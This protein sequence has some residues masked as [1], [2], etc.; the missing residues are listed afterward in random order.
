MVNTWAGDVVWDGTTWFIAEDSDTARALLVEILRDDSEIKVVGEA[1][2]GAEA[3]EM[4]CQLDPDL[5]T[6]DIQMPKVD[7]FTAIQEI[8]TTKPVP[9]VVISALTSLSEGEAVARA[10]RLNASQN[11]NLVR[12]AFRHCQQLDLIDRHDTLLRGRDG[13][14]A[15]NAGD[16][17]DH[18]CH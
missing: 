18:D 13:N 2:D 17:R 12:A 14:D 15:W 5:V 16:F 6:M 8:M 1:R 9:I 7:G 3:I 10:E 4:A 11:E